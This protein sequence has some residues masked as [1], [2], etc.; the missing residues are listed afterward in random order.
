MKTSLSA[1]LLTLTASLCAVV[2]CSRGDNG[3]GG[4]D[5]APPSTGG[6]IVIPAEL[7]GVVQ[8]LA[9]RC[10]SITDDSSTEETLR[11][12]RAAYK[13]GETDISL[14]TKGCTRMFLQRTADRE[15]FSAVMSQPFGFGVDTKT[16]E[17]KRTAAMMFWATF[18]DGRIEV[19][20]DLDANGVPEL[21]ESVVPNVAVITEQLSASGGLQHRTTAK[22][23]ADGLRVD[24]TEES[25]EDGKLAVSA[26][27]AGAR[28]SRKC[29]TDPPPDTA[30]P[31][32]TPPRPASPFPPSPHEIACSPE[33]LVKLDSLLEKATNGG[34]SCMEATGMQSIRFR[35]LRQMATTSFDFKC[36]DDKSFV[37][38]NDGGYGNV[39]P[40]RALI[41]I[42]PIL[43]TAVEAEQTATLYHELMH[44]FFV[45][46]HDVEALA[47]NSTN[48]AYADRVYACEQ[49]CFAKKPNTCHLAACTKKKICNVDKYAFEQ[50]MGK[51]IESCWSGHQVGA[52][53]RKKPGERQ[54]CTTKAECDAACGGQ[55]CESKSISCDDD[56]R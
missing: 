24:V 18:P 46:D 17:L 2:A 35:L 44:F 15:T 33:Q 12:A 27:Y 26:Q 55:E 49:L 19:R 41:W 36:T 47:D 37:A 23:G 10:E 9:E 30:P 31:P 20:G 28:V 21:K 53:C 4:G 34:S 6:D 8:K 48:L 54:W 45:H 50:M 52:L 1:R 43:F 32:T 16:L 14:S 29:S 13:R 25:V 38:A 40:G 3:S 39:F 7:D 5:P 11:E 22:V 51:E 56:C 42:N